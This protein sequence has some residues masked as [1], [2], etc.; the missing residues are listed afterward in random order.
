MY[1][2]CILGSIERIWGHLLEALTD[3]VLVTLPRLVRVIVL[4]TSLTHNLKVIWAY[5][6]L[7]R[8]KQWKISWV[9]VMMVMIGKGGLLGIGR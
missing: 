3:F 9:Y 5:G 1:M 6:V 4:R 7:C 8:F 2:G